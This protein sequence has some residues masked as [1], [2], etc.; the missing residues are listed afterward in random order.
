[1]SSATR[2]AAD[3]DPAADQCA[4][5]GE[6]PA[7]RVLD[8]RGVCAVLGHIGVLV[9]QVLARNADVVELDAPVVDAGQP[10]LVLTVRG[11]HTRQVVALGVA[12]RHHEAV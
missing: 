1:M 3:G 8:R 11:G 12:D 2:A 7:I 6:E 4:Q 9:Q 5:H 10:A